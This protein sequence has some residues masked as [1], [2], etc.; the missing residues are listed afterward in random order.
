MLLHSKITLQKQENNMSRVSEHI[1]KNHD[2]QS[3][4]IGSG[5]EEY[6]PLLAAWLLEMG[7]MLHWYRSERP[8]RR[9]QWPEVLDDEDFCQL[10]GLS[11]ITENDDD[12]EEDFDISTARRR[13]KKEDKESGL[14]KATPA[15]CKAIFKERLRQVREEDLPADLPLFGNISRLADMLGFSEAD[16]ALLTFAAIMS[17]FHTFRGAIA[18]RNLRTSNQLLCQILSR[19]TKL[20]EEDFRASASDGGMLITTGMVKVGRGMRDLEDKVDLMDGLTSVLLTPHASAQELV[21]RFLKKAGSPTLTLGNFPHMDKDTEVLLPYFK[22]ALHGRTEGVNIL[23]HGKPGVGKTEYVQAL[24]A[25][26]DVDLYEIAFADADGDPIKGEARLRAYSLCQCLLART[27]NALLMFDEIE[28]VFPGGGSDFIRMLFGGN[29]GGDSNGKAWINR[30]MERNPVPALWVSN[31]ISQIDPAYLRRF[32]YSVN[33]PVPPVQ[34]RLEIARHHF[35][36]FQPPVGW[37]ERVAASEESTPG[38]FDR[39][40]KVARIASG[41]DSRLAIELAGRALERS[42]TL[43]GQKAFPARSI[44]RTAYSLEYLN[45]DIDVAAIVKGLSS[46]PHGS[47]CFYGA[48]GT[49][50]S[51]LARHISDQI[52][53]PLLLKRA[54]DIMDKYVGETEKNIAAM[55]TEARDQGA[56]LVLDEAD[57]FLADRRDAHQNWEVTQVNELLTQMETFEGIFICTTN[58]MEKLDQASLRRFAFKLRF[59]PLTADQRWKMFRQE[60]ARL[61]GDNAAIESWESAVKG[62]E[63]LTPGDFAVAARQFELWEVPA[64]A[65]M[66]FEQLKKECAVKEGVS[67]RIGFG[68]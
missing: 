32:D 27:S 51:E 67:R 11:G 2:S 64:S 59:D 1:K 39:A 25:E 4:K 55:F 13:R 5:V 46:R 9:N 63:R 15:D 8:S 21:G 40:A 54:S 20:P 23:M 31:R 6:R 34:V 17:L 10:T 47:F 14:K 41:G 50:K 61:G 58:L 66:L 49:G 65:A 60:L 53:K 48:A 36:G 16:Q 45:T 18:S 52:G 24:A 35:G 7:L 62:L 12:S 37:L 38:Q 26:L 42:M 68:V 29:A 33:F 44:V 30:T 56:V 3:I 19:L 22:N 57:S 28:D 43:L